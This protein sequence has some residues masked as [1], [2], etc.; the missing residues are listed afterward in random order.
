MTSTAWIIVAT[1]GALAAALVGRAAVEVLGRQRMLRRVARSRTRETQ[2]DL[3]DELQTHGVEPRIAEALYREIRDVV[4]LHDGI[5]RFPVGADDDLRELYRF[6]TWLHAGYPDDPDLWGLAH[7][8]A[9]AA[10][11][12]FSY[13]HDA[14]AVELREVRTVRELAV[15]VQALPSSAAEHPTGPRSA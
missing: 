14:V 1:L 9:G 13:D 11:R 4:R 10:E 6:T 5:E 15:W 7:D 8:V 2:S 3:V 12:R